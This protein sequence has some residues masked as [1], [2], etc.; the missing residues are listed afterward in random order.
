VKRKLFL[1]SALIFCSMLYMQ[2]F[3]NAD[4]KEFIKK[5]STCTRYADDT[6]NRISV[7]LGW[8]SRKCYYQEFA[9]QEEV[10][11]SFKTLDLQK[12]SK[13]MKK[14]SYDHSKGITSLKIMEDYLANPEIC[15]QNKNG[16]RT[17][18]AKRRRY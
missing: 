13:A 8:S 16:A 4:S 10:Q 11:C 2:G 17:T 9:H 6:N 18:S 7:I 3:C 12:I 15:T 1:T 14:E 5:F